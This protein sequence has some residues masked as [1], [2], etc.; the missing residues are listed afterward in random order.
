MCAVGAGR[1]QEGEGG[2]DV[3]RQKRKGGKLTTDTAQWLG[4][5][6]KMFFS[7]S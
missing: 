1:R 7:C 6:Q 3:M 5:R 4:M 2:G